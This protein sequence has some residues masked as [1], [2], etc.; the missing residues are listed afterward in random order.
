MPAKLLKILVLFLIFISESQIWAQS[1][2]PF[3]QSLKPIIQNYSHAQH[4]ASAQ[5][6]DIAQDSSGVMYF[7]NGSGLLRFDGNNWTL[8][9]LSNKSLVRSMLLIDD[10]LYVGG[11]G[12][13]G[14]FTI[15]PAGLR[16]TNISERIKDKN[17]DVWK[18]IE[19]GGAIYFIVGTK[20]VFKYA[21]N[22]LTLLKH[23]KDFSI[24]SGFKCGDSIFIATENSGI[25]IIEN[26]TVK[27]TP[28]GADLAKYRISS[29]LNY[30]ADNLI[31]ATSQHG[32][33]LASKK[34]PYKTQAFK[35]TASEFFN[36]K[37]VYS[38][39]LLPD[40]NF[41]YSSLN[42]G[43]VV[44][45]KNGDKLYE[46]NRNNGLTVDAI[47]EMFVDANQTLWLATEDEIYKVFLN[48][49]INSY[50]RND[51]LQHL[52]SNAY[53][54]NHVLYLGTHGATYKLDISDTNLGM[55]SGELSQVDSKNIYNQGF[56]EVKLTENRKILLGLYLRGICLAEE[57][58]IVQLASIYSPL[59]AHQ[60]SINHKI[61]FVG[62]PSGIYL[63]KIRSDQNAVKLDSLGKFADIEGEIRQIAED[64]DGN[65]WLGVDN[66][67]VYRLQFD[68]NSDF[69]S[70]R[71]TRFTQKDGLP[72]NELYSPVWFHNNLFV[73]A[74]ENVYKYVHSSGDKAGGFELAQE[75]NRIINGKRLHI[76][77]LKSGKYDKIWIITVSGYYTGCYDKNKIFNITPEYSA[78]YNPNSDNIVF[79]EIN[80]NEY[81]IGDYDNFLLINRILNKQTKIQLPSVVF[82]KITFWNQKNQENMEFDLSKIS[83]ISP[84][85]LIL[86]DELAYKR[87]KIK[88]EF[89]LPTYV[90]GNK[91]Y[92]EYKLE[93]LDIGWNMVNS[94]NVV[95]YN[96]L[97]E[98][99]YIFKVRARNIDGQV[100][101]DT[102]FHF[103]V[104]PPFYRTFAAYGFYVL[105]IIVVFYLGQKM[106]QR[107]YMLKKIE[108]EKIIQ[109]RTAEI[110]KQKEEIEL[111]ANKL[112]S[113]AEMLK[114]SVNELR[115]FSLITK[116]ADSSFV[117]LNEKG[118]FE[119]WNEGFMR[120][121]KFKF[122]NFKGSN[123]NK[124]KHLV[125]PDLEEIINNFDFNLKSANY[126]THDVVEG[127]SFW[128]QTN[129]TPIFNDD[130][131]IFRWI[132]VDTDI[133]NVKSAEQE[134]MRKNAEIEAQRDQIFK[135]N[136][137]MRDSILYASRIQQAMLPLDLLFEALFDD[138]F[139]L[140]RPRDIVSGDFYWAANKN[141]VAFIAVAD[142]TGHGIPGAF[143]SL[144][145]MAY[146]NDLIQRLEDLNPAEL[147]NQLRER[148]ILA[149]HQRGKD[150]ETRDGLD[151]AMITINKSEGIVQFAGANNA[152][153]LYTCKTN[154]LFKLKPDKMP[155]GFYSQELPAAFTVNTF[156]Y[157][158]GNK[159]YLFTDGYRDQ[160]GGPL[161]KKFL[162]KRLEL[163]L[164]QTA[165]LPMQQQYTIF[166]NEMDKWMHGTSQIDDILV[167]GISI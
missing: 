61:L 15:S 28:I 122:R 30:N 115:Q 136:K 48:I 97:P 105:V 102:E 77:S 138:Y 119:W 37:M 26:D 106:Y 166:E 85:K 145:G 132:A 152:A 113:Q 79:A 128:Y 42:G 72:P 50:T 103:G 164:N 70:P 63:Y 51:G 4:R 73:L 86:N 3:I 23:D 124:I 98:G 41:A 111:Q 133:S 49:P 38:G 142:C 93:G 5:N 19:Y 156:P 31:I 101:G 62:N 114:L 17:G 25:A 144:L 110:T 148:F 35:T 10:K 165:C 54:F 130:G 137:E 96:A 159:L 123:F 134:I 146:L 143:L 157:I 78:G 108:L 80:E 2:A 120:L 32:L 91:P 22:N 109:D 66:S 59:F 162:T 27:L 129:I 163:L 141:G 52:L 139:I 125:R 14:Y 155:I 99:K 89:G 154:E 121:F 167:V 95:V 58:R 88:F 87:S 131:T 107:R 135:Q 150:G 60:Y 57:S 34:P 47:Y 158:P 82:S 20:K 21:E 24:F 84:N 56:V 13:F 67:G 151:I 92:F 116:Q 76:K 75:F 74:N 46:L 43:M 33:F 90:P 83:T 29:I 147:L 126:V 81:C 64:N 18:I 9:K 45:S 161:G 55:N 112:R 140:N 44:V 118:D 149:L 36:T 100:T 12:E 117:I 8:F 6:W 160:F 68:A 71:I 104:S 11:T 7:G 127:E 153:Y 1:R 40:G 53:F 69:K 39:E 16:Y 94:Q 65:I